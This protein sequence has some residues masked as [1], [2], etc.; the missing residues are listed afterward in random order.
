MDIRD[1]VNG[2][3]VNGFIVPGWTTNTGGAPG[4]RGGGPRFSPAIWAEGDVCMAAGLA[5]EG[6]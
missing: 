2:L 3:P 6:I 4:G 1:E 5:A